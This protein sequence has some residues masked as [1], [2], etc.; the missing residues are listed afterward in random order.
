MRYEHPEIKIH[1]FEAIRAM[2]QDLVSYT[3]AA[4]AGNEDASIRA[5]SAARTV[6]VQTIISFNRGEG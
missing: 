6:R 3:N 1:K 2:E 4:I 5:L